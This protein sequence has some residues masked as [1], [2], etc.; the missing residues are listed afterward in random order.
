MRLSVSHNNFLTYLGILGI[1]LVIVF[2]MSVISGFKTNTTI[3]PIGEKTKTLRH[4][5]LFKF[6]DGI[7]EENL[8]TMESAFAALPSKIPEIVAFEWGTNNSSL[9]KNKGFTHCFF[10]S[11]E[12]EKGRE[13]Y[14]PHPDHK[15][16]VDL[17]SA[18]IED[19][20][21]LDYWPE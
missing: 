8:K 19:A 10:V 16:F 21:V 6:K 20:L 5:V 3:S 1:G 12:N 2:A 17:A 18:Y 7:T 4:L 14:L 11:F 13:I 15:A 9:G